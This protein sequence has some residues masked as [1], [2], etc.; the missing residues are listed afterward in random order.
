MSLRLDTHAWQAVVAL[1][2]ASMVGACA[3][4]RNANTVVGVPRDACLSESAQQRLSV[5]LEE[6]PRLV[7]E[8]T[9]YIVGAGDLLVVTIY[10]F[11]PEGG[12]FVSDVRVD[13]RGYIRLPMLDPVRATGRTLTQVRQAIVFGLRTQEVL[14]EPLVSVFLRDYRGQQ[15]VVLGAVGKPGM[16]S[17]SSS[18]QTLVDVLSMAGGMSNGAGNSVLLQPGSGGRDLERQ[19]AGISA[20]LAVQSDKGNLDK[21]IPICVDSPDGAPN[22]ALVD[23]IMRGGDVV[24]VPE[25]GQAYIDGEVEKPGHYVLTRG[26]TL[27]QLISGAGGMTFA[28]DPTRVRLLRTAVT[29]F[30]SEWE[31]DV[32]AI[33]AQT[34]PDVRL[35][36]NDAVMIPYTTSRKVMFGLYEF[37]TAIVRITV[38]G[39]AAVF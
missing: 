25:A 28:A 3:A 11:R 29:G 2:L 13:D 21:K 20:A 16:Y 24:V 23:L 5:L 33:L 22:T 4:P 19:A 10:S 39:T 1:G 35:E 9:D 7:G 15:V 14:R 34:Q 32:S 27:T 30:Q 8:E 17:L 37:V 12:D 26:V 31:I 18:R 38:G 36:R 6:R